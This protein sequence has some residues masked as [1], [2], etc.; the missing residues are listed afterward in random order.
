MSGLLDPDFKEVVL[1]R[2]EVR[3]LIKVPKVG[4]VAGSF[5]IN[6]KITRSSKVRIIRD[7]IVIHE[8]TLES[9][10]RFKDDVREVVEGYECGISVDKFNDIKEGDIIEA[11]II[12][13]VKRQL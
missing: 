9:L 6:G 3:Q 4:S 1:G 10:R 11:F 8:G 7:S 5:I 2:A 13:E 12:E